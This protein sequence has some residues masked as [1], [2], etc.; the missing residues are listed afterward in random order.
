[1]SYSVNTDGYII[2]INDGSLVKD[3]LSHKPVH[4]NNAIKIFDK[5]CDIYHLFSKLYDILSKNYNNSISRDILINK[6][7]E[8]NSISFSNKILDII[9]D[10]MKLLNFPIKTQKML[11]SLVPNHCDI[12][13]KILSKLDSI[14]YSDIN[15][16]FINYHFLLKNNIL[17]IQKKFSLNN[18][19]GDEIIKQ[20]FKQVVKEDHRT[21]LFISD[22]KLSY[23][24]IKEAVQ[25]NGLALQFLDTENITHNIYYNFFNN[26]DKFN[27]SNKINNL[28]Y[29]EPFDTH[30]MIAHNQASTYQLKAR[31]Y[32]PLD[33]GNN[34]NKVTDNK[35]TDKIFDNLY[36]D[37]IL[38]SHESR[39][40]HE[41]HES[42]ESHKSHE[43]HESIDNIV[44][45]EIFE[46]AVKQNGLALQYIHYERQTDKIIEEAV[47]Q[48]GLALE[49]VHYDK[50]TDKIIEL[51]VT[52]NGCALEY[53]QNDK[54]TIKVLELAIKN[55]PF[56]I[57]YIHILIN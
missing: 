53:V 45:N 43:S 3:M 26:I 54:I 4:I 23:D 12:L 40:S 46:I 28:E 8:N 35:V 18:D 25:S 31:L 39:K 10:I 51:A 13:F 20:L 50:Q 15:F 5:I 9:T 44:T 1:M 21:I 29:Q 57:Q 55:N 48:N 17:L 24:I 2:N 33:D 47:S 49:Y 14:D 19:I 32:E 36:C 42:H 27:K 38:E 41:S 56:V 34:D 22:N 52:N 37:E 11:L 7:L 30:K 16:L 6:I